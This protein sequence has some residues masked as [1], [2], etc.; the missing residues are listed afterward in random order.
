VRAA[1]ETAVRRSRI[2][3]RTAQRMAWGLWIVTIAAAIAA[4]VLLVVTRS[5]PR[6]GF[7]TLWPLDL[8]WI[9]GYLS[10]P[11]VGLIVATRRPNN[12][13][14]WLLLLIGLSLGINDFT[15]YYADYT[16]THRPGA[17]PGGLA[18]GWVS[19]WI[20]ALIWP[21]M[22]L[23]FL[24]FP[25]GRLPS[26]RWRPLAWTVSLCGGLL[27]L[28]APFRAG[29]LEYFPTITNPVGIPALR[30]AVFATVS[31]GYFVLLLLAT[32][33]LLARFG[34][35]RG[36]E[37]QQLKWV[38]FAALLFGTYSVVV[39]RWLPEALNYALSPFVFAA[40]AAAIAVA[41]LKYRLYDI[42]RI[43]NR[44]LVYG[45]LTA[46]L[47]LV[48]AGGVFLFGEVLNPAG[49]ESKLAVAASTLAVAALFQPLRRRLQSAVDRRFNRRR[50]DAA[51]TIEAFA[52]RLRDEVDLDT[53]SAELLTV[54]DQTM[55]PTD[56]SLWLRQ[57]G[58]GGR[59]QSGADSP[60]RPAP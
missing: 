5:A 32:S 25:D 42:D 36:D 4:M 10:F 44:T 21:L 18:V 37:R 45:L 22:P 56:V 53:L 38:T 35:A 19:T 49:E 33:S 54:V 11:T 2:R 41:I 6:P 60:I 55:Q 30:P 12:P 59:V 28:I 29:S 51:R 1:Q 57:A 26:R 20:W 14:G 46:T 17:L 8:L 24:L 16:L 27:L 34:R 43:I 15:H 48:Y 3:P 52:V 39:P 13:L 9:V 23:V 47:A 58:D 7:V 50:Y 40:F 31:L